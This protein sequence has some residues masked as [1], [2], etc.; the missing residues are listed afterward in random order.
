MKYCKRCL[1]PGNHSLNI[2]FDEEGV[3]SGC[4]VHEEKD[5]LDWTLRGKKLKSLFEGYKN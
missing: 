3:C 1:Y 4:R 2:V 5:T